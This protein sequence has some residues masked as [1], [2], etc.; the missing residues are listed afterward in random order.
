M[1][2]LFQN[3]FLFLFIIISSTSFAQKD[4]GKDVEDITNAVVNDEDPINKYA[5][6][7]MKGLTSAM[8]GEF[9]V[10]DER[11]IDR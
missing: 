7:E 4:Q 1:K 10:T 11:P 3:L 2:K 8:C 5:D 9:L 6:N